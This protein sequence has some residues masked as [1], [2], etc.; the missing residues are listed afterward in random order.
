[1]THF[2]ACSLTAGFFWFYGGGRSILAYVWVITFPSGLKHNRGRSLMWWTQKKGSDNKHNLSPDYPW[3]CQAISWWEITL[4]RTNIKALHISFNK[5]RQY[6]EIVLNK[7]KEIQ[8][9]RQY[10]KFLLWNISCP[11]ATF[12]PLLFSA[13]HSY[14]P[15]SSGRK[16][17]ISRTPVEW[18]ILILP[19]SGFPSALL[20]EMEGTGLQRSHTK[21]HTGSCSCSHQCWKGYCHVCL[22]AC[23]L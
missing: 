20:H 8:E 7:E 3:C 17:G 19:G 1:M 12:R 2:K 15:A 23:L 16:Y 9:K 5:C 4:D 13:T 11:L 10:T 14:T 21:G 6:S 22:S 18:L